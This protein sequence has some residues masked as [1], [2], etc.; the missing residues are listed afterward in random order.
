MAAKSYLLKTYG[1]AVYA[2]IRYG[3]PNIG[4]R[5]PKMERVYSAPNHMAERID[6]SSVAKMFICVTRYLH[7]STTDE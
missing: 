1:S 7:N 3:D 6:R 4:G 2:G 5:R